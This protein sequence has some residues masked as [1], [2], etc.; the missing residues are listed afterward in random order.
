ME[1]VICNTEINGNFKYNLGLMYKIGSVSCVKNCILDMNVE[2]CVADL[3]VNLIEIIDSLKEKYKLE[4][5]ESKHFSSSV[6]RY[7]VFNYPMNGL[8]VPLVEYLNGILVMEK[9]VK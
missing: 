2:L 6:V 1:F 4:I 9:L 7:I 3:N 8:M 5:I